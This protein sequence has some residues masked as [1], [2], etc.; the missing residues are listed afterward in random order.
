M[1]PVKKDIEEGIES[2]RI[3]LRALQF[4]STMMTM[5]RLS[6]M[7]ENAWCKKKISPDEYGKY[8]KE[9]NDII[10]GSKLNL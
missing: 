2:L 7:I 10:S 8:H 1:Y 5:K 6:G 9:I 3:H 4:Y